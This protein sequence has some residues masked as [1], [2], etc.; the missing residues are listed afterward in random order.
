V[1]NQLLLRPARRTCVLH[2]ASL[3]ERAQPRQW[4][5]N[6]VSAIVALKWISLIADAFF[7]VTRIRQRT[8]AA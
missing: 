4:K 6:P 5:E 3:G 7:R 8:S 2:R 1:A